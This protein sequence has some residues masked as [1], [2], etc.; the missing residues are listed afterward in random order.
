MYVTVITPASP[1]VSWLE[2]DA[3]LKLSG[4]TSQQVR[5][6]ALIAAATAW[7]QEYTGYAIGSQTLE[8]RFD[9][10]GTSPIVL[11]FGPVTAIS[12]IKHLDSDNVEQTI[13]DTV[14]QKLTDG[15]VTLKADQSWPSTYDDP[16]AVRVRYVAGDEPA[17]IKAAILLI[18]AF[19]NEN[20]DASPDDALL[21]GPVKWL[22]A[23]YRAYR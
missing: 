22:L 12:S 16:E 11:P 10:F 18:V 17:P 20:R 4:D 7:A 15:R 21:S 6:E 8:A 3:H 14:Y 23:P 13:A 1:A 19:L 5:V 9:S 2:A